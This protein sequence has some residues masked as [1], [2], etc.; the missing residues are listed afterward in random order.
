MMWEPNCPTR[1]EVDTS[2]FATGR[3]LLQKLDNGLW[4]P[5]AFCFQSMADTKH[6]YEVYNKEMLTIIHTLEDWQHYLKGLPQ[7]FE[8]ISDHRNLQYWCTA[9]N[10]T[11]HQAHWSLYLS[12]FDFSLTHKPGSSNTQVD[13]LSRISTYL[14]LDIDDNQDQI[15][16]MPDHFSLA[17]F[18]VVN[19]TGNLE[20]DICTA[21]K[22]DP[23][24][25]LALRLLHNHAPHQ[26]TSN[27]ANWEEYEGLIFFKERVYVPKCLNLHQCILYLCHDSISTGH[28]G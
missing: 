10:L 15:V 21:H 26:L 4:H 17:T 16:F 23:Q 1:L 5:I 20:Q 11:C 14:I 22:L 24:V 6:N 12:W 28:P 8:I 13:L 2:R 25:L 9:Q 18:L 19:N 7:P 27:L 3:V